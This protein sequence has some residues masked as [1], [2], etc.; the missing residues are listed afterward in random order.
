M[1]KLLFLFLATASV[2]VN[3]QELKRVTKSNMHFGEIYY[4]LKSNRSIKQGQY[5]KYF[6]SMNMYDKA[7]ESF[8]IYDKN[9]QT[10]TWIFCDAESATNAL[11]SIG[12]Y[13]DDKKDGSWVF[14]YEPESENEDY[15]NYSGSNKQTNVTLPTKDNEQFNITLDTTGLRKAATGEYIDNKK[16]GIWSYFYK[17]GSLACKYDFSTN[18]MILNNGLESYDQLGGIVRFIVLFHKSGFEKRIKMQPF[19]SQN[20]S[21]VFELI[22]LND[23]LEIKRINS[24]GSPGFAKTIEDILIKMPLDWISYDPRLEENNIKVQINY[25]VQGNIGTVTLDSIKPLK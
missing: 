21:V 3:A 7:I 11:I 10:G 2:L 19:F 14:F 8:G 6:E 22:T 16:S 5:L 17:N 9:Q 1:K 18:T 4:V 24:I 15:I 13:K 25:T 12:E 23:S 20:S